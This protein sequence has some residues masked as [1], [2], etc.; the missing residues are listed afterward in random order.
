[1][2][3]PLLMICGVLMAGASWAASQPSVRVEPATLQG[4][5]VLLQQTANGAIHDYLQSW[6]SLSVAL[7]QNNVDLLD[8][9][10][11]GDAKSKLTESIRDQTTLGIRAHYQDLAHDLQIVFYSPE[12]LSIELTDLVQYDV[13][14]FDH[15]KPE[16][17]QRVRARYVV[18][19]TPAQVRWRVRVLQAMPGE[20]P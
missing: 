12:G 10:F 18:V 13:Q 6:R 15:G 5:R 19:L 8:A 16:P 1:M 20:N 7:E 2:L 14:L 11:I 17:E 9:D 4:P 3:R